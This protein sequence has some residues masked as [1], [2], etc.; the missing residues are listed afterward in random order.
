M[1]HLNDLHCE[2]FGHCDIIGD[3]GGAS[4]QDQLLSSLSRRVTN[5]NASDFVQPDR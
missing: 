4:K 3:D 2:D 1:V 5:D